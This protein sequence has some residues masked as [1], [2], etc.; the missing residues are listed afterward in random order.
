[1]ERRNEPTEAHHK[2]WNLDL[3]P[4]PSIGVALEYSRDEFREISRL[5]SQLNCD[6]QLTG[7]R[8]HN[9]R[10]KRLNKTKKISANMAKTKVC[11]DSAMDRRISPH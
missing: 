5:S 1:M 4:H 10:L 11:C 8:L 9:D 7:H 3:N 6:L 2:V